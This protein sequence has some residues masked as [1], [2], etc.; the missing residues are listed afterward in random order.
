MLG[1]LD[2]D[3]E[4]QEQTAA[5][6]SARSTLGDGGQE[7]RLVVVEEKNQTPVRGATGLNAIA[8]DFP[9]ESALMVIVL[10]EGERLLES[11]VGLHSPSS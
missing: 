4:V 1:G 3:L 2:G 11:C 10:L 6:S 9:S 5:L 7:P 8:E